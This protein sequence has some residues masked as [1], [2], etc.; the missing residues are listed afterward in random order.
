MRSRTCLCCGAATLLVLAAPPAAAARLAPISGKLSKPGYTLIALAG[1]GKASS[2]L[3]KKHSFK[4]RPPT[5][6]VTLQLRA[7]DGVYAGPVVVGEKDNGKLA[8]VGVKAGA[9][10]GKVVIKGGKGYAKLK[11]KLATK[12]VDAKR[13]ATAKKGAPIGAGNF[14][15]VRV[16]KLKGPSSDPDLDGVPNL[17]DIDDNGNLILDKVD[18]STTRSRARTAQAE[19]PFYIGTSLFGGWFG[20]AVNANVRAV[21]DADIDQSLATRTN[22]SPS[23]SCPA[24]LSS[25]AAGRRTPTTHR[26]GS[27][28]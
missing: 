9:K 21:T 5:K 14:G 16:K 2:V 8:V 13:T 18:R 23:A 17:L 26:A 22:G 28:A 1:S 11:K 6:E 15:R 27:A 19:S 3:V 25:T 4:L 20:D 24:V 10:L 12:F 7:P